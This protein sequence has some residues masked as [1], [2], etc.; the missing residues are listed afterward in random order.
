MFTLEAAH[1]A[2]QGVRSYDLSSGLLSLIKTETTT[3]KI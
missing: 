2:L 3:I 1:E